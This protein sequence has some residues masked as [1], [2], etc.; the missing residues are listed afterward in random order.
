MLIVL[1]QEI[2]SHKFKDFLTS[3]IYHPTLPEIFLGGTSSHGIYAI[4]INTG[5]VIIIF[6]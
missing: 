4:D 6:P 1:G 3:V 5:K 2:F